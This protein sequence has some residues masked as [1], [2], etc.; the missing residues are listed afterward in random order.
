MKLTNSPK[1]KLSLLAAFFCV[2]IAYGL[3]FRGGPREIAAQ[4]SQTEREVT[5]P[6]A[7]L[8]SSREAVAE[9]ASG[10]APAPGPVLTNSTPP[11][12]IE[13]GQ[14]LIVPTIPNPAV[15]G[16][17]PKE[18][19]EALSLSDEISLSFQQAN[20]EMVVQWL[21]KT[22]GK[23]VVKHPRVQC[24]LTIVSSKKLKIREALTLVYRA[25]S[26][27]GFATIES[28]KSILIVPEGQEPKMSPELMDGNSGEIP[29]GRQRLIKVFPLKN[30]LPSELKEKIRGVLSEKGTIDEDT[31]ANQIIVTDYTDNVRLIGE[32]IKELDIAS[33][34][35]TVI[36]IFSLRYLEAEE[37]ASLLNL[38][39][40]SQAGSP[41]PPPGSS[42]SSGSSSQSS[43]V[44][45]MPPGMVVSSSSSPPAGGPPPPKGGQMSGQEIHLWPDRTSNRLIVASPKSKLGEV[46]RLIDILDAAKP[47]D[48]GI[49]VI[50]LKHVSAEDL[51]K[52]IAP[53][54]QKLSGRSLKDIIEVTSNIRSNSLIVLSSEA[55]FAELQKLTTKLDTEEAQERVMQAFALK[56]ADAEDVAEQL[57]ELNQD[58]SSSSRYVYYYSPFSNNQNRKKVSV[59][60]DKRR[61]TVIVQAS[62]GA[63][64]GI[65]AMIR[66]L[67]KPVTDDSL[68]PKIYPLKYVSAVDIETVLNELFV[69]KQEQRSY[70]DYYYFD[71]GNSSRDKDAGRMFGKVRIT[72]EPYSNS[73]IVTSNSPEN[74]EAVEAV[75]KQLDAPSQAGESTLRI[76]L[77]FATASDVAKS[78]NILFA[79]NGS[80]PLRPV[81]PQRQQNQNPQQQ[82][83]QQNS[84]S[85]NFDLDEESDEEGYFPWLGGQPDN[86]RTAD[87]RSVRPVSD[88]VGKV[89][90]VP[91][92]RSNSLLLSA[93]VHY[94]P[95]VLKLIEDLDAPTSEVLIEARI[96]EVSSDYLDK[97]GVRWSPDGSKV[98]SGSDYDNSFIIGSSG[99]YTKGFGG[100]TSGNSSGAGSAISALANLKSGVLESTIS[101]DF[102][103]QFL[104]QNTA[105]TVLA[106][107]QIN[108]KDNETG[109][110]FVGQQVPIPA[111]NQVNQ[112]GGQNTQIGY[113]DVGVVLEVTPHINKSGDVSLKIHAESSSIVPGQTVL[114]GAVFDTRNFKT[115]LEAKSGETLVLGGI[116]QRQV[117]DTVRKT[118]ILG[119]IPGLGWAFKKKDKITREVELMVFLRTTVVRTPEDAKAL[120]E[121]T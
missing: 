45:S 92:P 79:K 82:G 76:G 117:S 61:N 5:A 4:N 102:L 104:K 56:N 35:D 53:L 15:A 3:L 31:R 57:Q 38:V 65:G 47:Q 120:L 114:G 110:L 59:V 39:L 32:L 67:D 87:G 46:K 58:Q 60:A 6:I 26:L 27:E 90:V 40:N 25:L 21:A 85:A 80:P 98:F 115:H 70:F 13:P 84:L 86:Q 24:Q 34:S 62:P 78:I 100:T 7:E 44:V 20:I 93:N 37:L 89:R 109:K 118:P 42:G 9:A 68:A 22:T 119:S 63:I 77:R 33:V 94:F 97:L 75:L 43:R 17:Q 8:S 81:Q 51:V 83:G 95:Q 69:K 28:S 64:D 113:K 116:I 107:P 101:M 14:G 72:S 12:P 66:E 112:L 121:E 105:A 54:Y 108:I 30:I 11:L 49:R 29:E 19:E 2:V 48:V 71:S 73:I 88:L 18:E 1:F 91:D 36:E 16:S 23:S 106:Q 10:P 96:V 41:S 74:L 50:A 111:N 103:V 99:K 52:E 55:N